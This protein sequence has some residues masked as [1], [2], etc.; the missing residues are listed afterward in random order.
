[1]VDGVNAGDGSLL[2]TLVPCAPDVDPDDDDP[3]ISGRPAFTG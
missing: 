2:L 3:V 1:M